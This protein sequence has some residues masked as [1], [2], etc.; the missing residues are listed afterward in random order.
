MVQG[1]PA[2]RPTGVI[3]MHP[4]LSA[5]DLERLVATA[6]TGDQPAWQALVERFGPALIRMARS[7]G[8]STHEAEDAVQETWMR[9]LRHI[10]TLREPRAL[11][12]WLKTTVRNESLR[13]RERVQRERPTAEELCADVADTTTFEAQ[14]GLDAAECGAAVARA[15]D[16]LPAR[17]RKL[18]RALFTESEPSY[19]EVA[20]QLGMPLGSIGPIRRRCL[21]RLRLDG[22]LRRVAEALD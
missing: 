12:G 21:A 11:S 16:A 18:M 13:V 19:E 1:I 6:A 3:A 2:P 10:D 8:L 4:H 5:H 20:S 17:H 15:L 14:A 22:R 9:L 7:H